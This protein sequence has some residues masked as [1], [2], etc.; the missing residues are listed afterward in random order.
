MT[1]LFATRHFSASKV[2]AIGVGF[3]G[4]KLLTTAMGEATSDF[5]VHRFSPPV[6]V[7]VAG[8]VF[9]AS[10]VWQFTRPRYQTLPYWFCVVMVSVFGT[11]CADV[12]HVGLGIAYSVSTSVFAVA[13]AT[14]FLV[15]HRVEGTL[16]IHSITTARRELFYWLTV[17]ATFAL[18]TAAGDLT[19]VALHLG[20]ISSALIFTGFIV[21][22]GLAFRFAGANAVAAFWISYVL[23]R[24]LGASYADW[25]GVSRARGGLNWGP[26]NVALLFSAFIVA[27][28]IALGRV[29][30]THVKPLPLG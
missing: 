22:P 10:L 26:G 21:L 8:L 24:P 30:R 9:L 14:I 1:H 17:T 25:L 23:T 16:S 28:V 15:W 19:A 3:W 20:Y 13:L 11:M 7:V 5:F 18:G 4:I 29:E 6:V 2:P 27:G 12:A